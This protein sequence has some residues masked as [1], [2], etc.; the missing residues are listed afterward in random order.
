[1]KK[2]NFNVGTCAHVASHQKLWTT[3]SP[4]FYSSLLNFF[5]RHRAGLPA[6]LNLC[7]IFSALWYFCH[8]CFRSYS[9]LGC[10]ILALLFLHFWCSGFGT[11]TEVNV[12]NI[13]INFE[14]FLHN[15]AKEFFVSFIVCSIQS[16]HQG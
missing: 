13:Q 1:M 10:N 4:A 9:N 11:L 3:R 5:D 8:S 7:L 6:I 15:N 14:N 16:L 12:K 2:T